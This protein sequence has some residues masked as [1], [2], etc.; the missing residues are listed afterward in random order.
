MDTIVDI[1]EKDMFRYGETLLN[2]LLK[3]RTT[4]HNII[5]ATDDYSKFGDL[6]KAESEIKAYQIINNINRILQPRIIKTSDNQFI[7]TREKGEV[8]TPSWICNEQNNLID[9]Q[10]FGRKDVFNIQRYKSWEPV[11]EKIVFSKAKGRTWKDYVDL[12]RMEIACGEAPYLVSRYDTVTGKAIELQSRIGLL[13]RKLRV[14]NENVD[15]K[16]EWKNWAIRAYQSIYGY[17]YQGDNLLLARINL[18][19]TYIENVEFKFGY[20]P[21]LKELKKIATIISW[22]IWQMDG[23]TFTVPF[24]DKRGRFRQ[25]SVFDKPDNIDNKK[26]NK[27]CK[28]KDWRSNKIIEYRSLM[29]G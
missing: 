24:C 2:I 13:D 17:E 19:Y 15:D 9:E 20:K 18:L 28:I 4:N 6:Y 10:W 29:G 8:F 1:I 26:E 12:R 11:K 23:I 25:L 5:W 21:D 14:I 3:D 7:R 22:N 27:Y 16:E